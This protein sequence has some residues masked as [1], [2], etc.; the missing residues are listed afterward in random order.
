MDRSRLPAVVG[1]L[2][3]ELDRLRNAVNGRVLDQYFGHFGMARGFFAQT[4]AMANT[5]KLYEFF[6]VD[7]LKQLQR[8]LFLLNPNNEAWVNAEIQ[9]QK[10]QA[11]TP[12][13]NHVE[14]VRFVDYLSNQLTELENNLSR[15]ITKIS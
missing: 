3:T 6:S 1:E 10:Q 13:Y 9:R 8:V 15:L 7:D 5:G 2:K 11:A 12:Q 14:A 4:V